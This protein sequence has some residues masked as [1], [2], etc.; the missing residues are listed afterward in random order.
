MLCLSGSLQAQEERCYADDGSE[1]CFPEGETSFADRLVEL[2]FGTP[3]TKIAGASIS[4]AA[5]GAPDNDPALQDDLNAVQGYVTLG[6]GGVLTVAFDDNRLSDIEG[7]DLYVFEIGGDIEPTL[8]EISENGTDWI[9]IGQISGGTATVDIGLAASE[10]A[11]FSFVRL[12]D[13]RTHCGGRWPGADIDA[14]G[15]IGSN[16]AGLSKAKISVVDA[17]TLNVLSEVSFGQHFRVR[18]EYD[19][20]P[21]DRRDRFVDLGVPGFEHVQVSA[22]GN[23]LTFLS[24]PVSV[25]LPDRF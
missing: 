9:E 19:D 16:P 6:C 10:G 11:S 5:I 2:R 4:T 17:T 14:I 8:V 24:D 15:A 18:L 12:T 13:L 1:I 25:T 3:A 20:Q 21:L 23:G 22:V 7:P